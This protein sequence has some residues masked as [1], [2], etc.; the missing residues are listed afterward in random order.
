MNSARNRHQFMHVFTRESLRIHVRGSRTSTARLLFAIRAPQK[1]AFEGQSEKSIL[2]GQ[3]PLTAEI[4]SSTQP[5]IPPQTCRVAFRTRADKYPKT[6]AQVEPQT[7]SNS[8]RRL[9]R[10]SPCTLVCGA[11]ASQKG[12]FF[13]AKQLRAFQ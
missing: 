13:A 3:G 1:H 10:G 7:D 8:C 12:C 11:R 4:S 5:Y 2:P 9:R 6:P